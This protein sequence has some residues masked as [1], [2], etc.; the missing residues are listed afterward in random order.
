VGKKLSVKNVKKHSFIANALVMTVRLMLDVLSFIV[1]PLTAGDTRRLR[2]FTIRQ[3]VHQRRGDGLFHYF[4]YH[5]MK[6]FIPCFV[7]CSPYWAVPYM[8]WFFLNCEELCRP[9][10]SKCNIHLNYVVGAGGS[11]SLP[12]KFDFKIIDFASIFAIAANWFV[13][14]RWRMFHTEM[15]VGAIV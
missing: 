13:V 12:P 15:L 9:H 14:H 1:C 11:G 2:L 3:W 5:Y 10:I 6:C 4:T 8:H 7:I